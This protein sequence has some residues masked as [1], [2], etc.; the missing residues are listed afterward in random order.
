MTGPADLRVVEP[1]EP[2]PAFATREDWLAA[3]RRLVDARSEASWAFADWLAAGHAAWGKE[4]VREAAEATGATPGKIRHY[5]RVSTTY[6]KSR[7]RLGLTFSH[8]LETAFLPD[9][10]RDRLLD[11]AEAEGWPRARMRAA[12][13]EASLE[14][15]IARQRQAIAQLKRALKAAQADAHDTIAQTR[16][17]LGAERRVVRDAAGRAATMVEALVESGVPGRLHG[18]ARRGLARDIRRAATALAGDVNAALDRIEA[19]LATLEAS[20]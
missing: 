17:R 1:G 12:A 10:D 15:K 3:G 9:A 11:A 16:S 5:L 4:A 7:R 13:R 2:A 18:N 6:P 19:A 14:G 20:A 8:H